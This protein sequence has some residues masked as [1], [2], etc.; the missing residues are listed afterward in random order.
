MIFRQN[1]WAKVA[2]ERFIFKREVKNSGEE[3][4]RPQI[5]FYLRVIYKGNYGSDLLCEW[6]ASF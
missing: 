5:L 1:Q 3:T 4:T 6:N 2:K